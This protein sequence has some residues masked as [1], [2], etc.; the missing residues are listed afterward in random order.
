M[1]STI[2]PDVME[3]GR[4]I[5]GNSICSLDGRESVKGLGVRRLKSVPFGAYKALVLCKE[6]SDASIN[7]ADGERDK[8]VG[9]G[10]ELIV[11]CCRTVVTYLPTYLC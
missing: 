11:V 1:I 3:G 8:H 9:V 10:G 4:R 5:E 7:F 2:E 6:N